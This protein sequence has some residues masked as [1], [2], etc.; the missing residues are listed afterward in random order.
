MKLK[1]LGKVNEE[2]HQSIGHGPKSMPK[3]PNVKKDN[4]FNLYEN[5]DS[6]INFK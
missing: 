4:S 6:E 1:H 2:K 5:L 3:N